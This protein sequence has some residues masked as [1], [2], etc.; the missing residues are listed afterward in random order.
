MA[1]D[2]EGR[3]IPEPQRNEIV[4][5]WE[6]SPHRSNGY[7]HCLVMGWQ[8]MH[9]ELSS[10]AVERLENMTADEQAEGLTIKVRLIEMEYG[11]LLDAMED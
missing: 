8:D 11:E 6:I 10:I 1:C 5:V 9:E 3:E 4:K 2:H 7:S